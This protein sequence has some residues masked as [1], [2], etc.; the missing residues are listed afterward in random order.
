MFKKFFGGN[1]S[2][3]VK[4]EETIG[5][6]AVVEKESTNTEDIPV[7]ITYRDMKALKKSR[8]QDKIANNPIFKNLY[9]IKN[10][11]S[12]KV[13]EVRAASSFH[14]CKIMGWKPNQDIL[15]KETES[16]IKVVPKESKENKKNDKQKENQPS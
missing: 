1:K 13:A 4:K 7:M 2:D 11:K 5:S 9:V 16:I 14:A 3:D 12:V 15:V 10:T 6:E 8:Y